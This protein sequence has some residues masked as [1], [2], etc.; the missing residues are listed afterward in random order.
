MQR[1]DLE[2][3]LRML[4]ADPPRPWS[5]GVP[6][7]QDGRTK[8][9]PIFANSRAVISR[10]PLAEADG[11]RTRL[12]R[13]PGHTGFED[14][15]GHQAPSRLPRAPARAGP[16]DEVASQAGPAAPGDRAGR[17]CG[18]GVRGVRA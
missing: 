7:L 6:W 14:R 9:S 17:R 11:N 15:E 3:G 4:A 5:P 16:E 13:M 2:C 8:R 18:V 1:A 12:T 10:T